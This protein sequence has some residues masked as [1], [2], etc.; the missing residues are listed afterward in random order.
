VVGKR[1]ERNPTTN[2]MVQLCVVATVGGCTHMDAGASTECQPSCLGP[3][4]HHPYGKRDIACHL[5]KRVVGGG[6]G[7]GSPK[8]ATIV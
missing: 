4:A 3:H 6:G 8:E 5:H 2:A 7:C 1:G